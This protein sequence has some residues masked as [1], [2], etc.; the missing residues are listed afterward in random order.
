MDSA[1]WTALAVF[2]LPGLVLALVAGV[3]APASFAAAVPTTFG[4][5]GLSAWLLGVVGVRFTWLSFSITLVFFLLLAAAW[6]YA[7]AYR[8]R[9]KNSSSWPQ[10]L[11]PREHWRHGGSVH[12]WWVLPGAGVATGAWLCISRMMGFQEDQPYKWD[13]IVQGWDVQWHANA[14][15]FVMET[16]V[17]SSTRMGELQSP[18]SHTALFYPSAFHAV[19]AL[20]AQAAGLEPIPA[21]NLASIVLPGLLVPAAAAALAW[22]ILRG[23]GWTAWIASG[24]A[25]IAVYALPVVLWVSDYVGV[26]PYIV[27]VAMAFMVAAMFA[28]APRD[29]ALAF[30]LTFGF[31]GVL[32]AHP[33]AV[34]VLLLIVPLYWLNNTLIKRMCPGGRTRCLLL[35]PRWSARCCSCRRCWR[36]Q[37]KPVR[38]SSGNRSSDSSR[39][40]PGSWR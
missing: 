6:R 26:R 24:L 2:A 37:S 40:K 30:P 3:R 39:R 20:F 7:F 33:S 21:L 17:A 36:V 12:P 13:N 15:R 38:S 23:K 28:A 22:L 35:G 11:F 5:V 32:C 34:T 8:R 4:L 27:A 10:A 25:P 1:V 14:V 29:P 31:I 9:A 19:T 18:E 16:G